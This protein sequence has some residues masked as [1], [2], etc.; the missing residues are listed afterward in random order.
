M[1]KFLAFIALAASVLAFPLSAAEQTKIE[2][3]TLENSLEVVVI[4]NHRVPA[5]S[6]M[7]WLRVGSA[8]DPAGKSGLAHFHE[9]M[10]F[11]GT[12]NYPA[13]AYSDKIAAAGGQQN[14][15]TGRDATAYYITI[16]REKLPLAMELEADRLRALAP[17]DAAA[18]KEKQVIIEER[19]Q[20]I[21]NTPQ[22]LF[23]EQMS[24]ALFRNHPYRL[25]VI[26]WMHEMEK[27]TKSDVLRFHNSWYHPNNAVLILSGDI[28]AGEA[29]PLVERYYGALPKT[30]VPARRWNQE[31]PQNSARRL[32][33]RHPNLKQPVWARI[34]A[35]S[36]LGYGS[37]DQALPLLVLSH[38]LGGGK[39]SRLYRSLVSDRRIASDVNVSYDAFSLGPATFEI[40]V[41]PEPDTP[42]E[43]LEKAVDEE[44]AAAMKPPGADDLSR[45]KSLL[46]A[47]SVYARDGLE[48][49]ARVMGW[50][51]MTGL[52]K[53]YFLRWPE[54]IDAVTPEQV[55][56]AAK[57]A[58]N[59][60]ASVTGFL[61]PMDKKDSE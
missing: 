44:L 58:F 47:E 55:A 14:A 34:Y 10:M 49:M 26:G 42:M 27:L 31:P 43:T 7:L 30:A 18:K 35:A 61:L 12:A 15:F 60:D 39:T 37:K 6:H 53:D 46:K 29:R 50:I 19:R 11:E 54:L 57:A 22:A 28:T 9:H 23:S 16:A 24:A 40:S 32:A 52:P 51:R 25:P 21:E 2:S 38:L 17:A 3:F 1:K 45:T 5:V 41:V 56:Q 33:F 20:R 48:S 36:S 13:G 4:P 59:P 8:D